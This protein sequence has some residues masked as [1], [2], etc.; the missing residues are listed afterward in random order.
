MPPSAGDDLL[1]ALLALLEMAEIFTLPVVYTEQYPKGLGSTVLALREALSEHQRV[2]KREFSACRNDVFR[3]DILPALPE[4]VIV[5]GLE[6]HVCVLLTALDLV[7]S[8][9]SVFVPQDA[10]CSRSI[11][12]LESGLQMLRAAGVVVTNTETLI[13]ERLQTAESEAFKRLSQRLR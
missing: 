3:R 5:T 6:A 13:F 11:R 8:G 4:D 1:K 9:R 12:N 10:V 2:E 7:R